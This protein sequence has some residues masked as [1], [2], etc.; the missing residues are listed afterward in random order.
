MAI[1]KK[2]AFPLLNTE[3]A[4]EIVSELGRALDAHRD[5]TGKF[6]TMLVCRTKPKADDLDDQSPKRTVFGR[7]YF[8][9]VNPHLHDHPGFPVIGKDSEHMHHMARDLARLIRDDTDIK[10]SQYKAFVKSVDRF[11]LDLRQLLSEAWDFLRYNDP[12]TGVMTRTAMQSRLEEERERVRR[13]GQTCCVGIMDLDHFK[14][15]NDS[16][17]HQAGDMVLQAV[18]GYVIEN[19]RRYDQVFRYGG[20]EFVFLVPNST[21]A[22]AKGVL[23]RLRR[24]VKRQTVKIGGGKSLHVSASFGVAELLPDIPANDSIDYADQALYAAKNAGR[25]RVH[26][27]PLSENPKGRKK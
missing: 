3:E 11:R 25:N 1:K 26:V 6:R 24:G 12:L 27:W 8:G 17:G 13:G 9:K 7:W 23:D 15:V 20:E 16:H 22:Q 5:W 4:E 19:L 14:D 18:A 10:P 2:Q 21:L